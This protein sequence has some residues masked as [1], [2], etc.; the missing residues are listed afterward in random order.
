MSNKNININFKAIDKNEIVEFLCAENVH[1][2]G[3]MFRI[4]L[5]AKELLR[6]IGNNEQ[7]YPADIIAN[8]ISV[9]SC[10]VFSDKPADLLID[11]GKYYDFL[12]VKLELN[13]VY[14]IIDKML[15]LTRVKIKEA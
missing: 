13:P 11:F 6:L 15:E 9:A 2:Y 12:P 5:S 8:N 1:E 14:D 4:R 3:I 7:Q 10:V